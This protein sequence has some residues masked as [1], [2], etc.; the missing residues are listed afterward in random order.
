MDTSNVIRV[1]SPQY[2]AGLVDSYRMGDATGYLLDTDSAL[3]AIASDY[4]LSVS[5]VRLALRMAAVQS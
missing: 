5:M 1:P 4:R 3:Q 2:I